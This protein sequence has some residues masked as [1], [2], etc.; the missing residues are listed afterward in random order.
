[1]GIEINSLNLP[2]TS[3]CSLIAQFEG[4]QGNHKLNNGQYMEETLPDT[5]DF[6]LLDLILL[7]NISK[8]PKKK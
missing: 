4:L 7:E 3:T 2:K 6:I 1:M 5:G 8:I